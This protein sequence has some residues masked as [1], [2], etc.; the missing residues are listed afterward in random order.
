MNYIVKIKMFMLFK[1]K[2]LK[3]ILG[4]KRKHTGRKISHPRAEA[5][6]LR[7]T[8]TDGV[9]EVLRGKGRLTLFF[10]YCRSNVERISRSYS[11][12][13][14]VN[15]AVCQSNKNCLSC[16]GNTMTCCPIYSYIEA[17][18]QTCLKWWTTDGS[19]STESKLLWK[20][21]NK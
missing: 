13:R 10:H 5:R 4:H 14:G 17:D 8:Y 19:E 1:V 18:Y 2:Q 12:F 21:L 7:I 20:Y 9:P 11:P 16:S 3:Y 6:W 15:T